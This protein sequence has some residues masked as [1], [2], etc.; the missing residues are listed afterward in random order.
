M[1]IVNLTEMT[2]RH[3]PCIGI[4]ILFPDTSGATLKITDKAVICATQ[5]SWYKFTNWGRLTHICINKIT[6]I[7]SDNYLSPDRRQAIIKTN[8]GA[9]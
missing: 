7:G 1:A 9:T 5:N 4:I 8:A 3:F 2:M 6:I